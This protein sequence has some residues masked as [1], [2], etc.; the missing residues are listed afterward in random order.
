M[1]SPPQR[2]H[3]LRAR[4]DG[5]RLASIGILTLPYKVSTKTSL[6]DV[7]HL[8]GLLSSAATVDDV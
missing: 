6:N 4:V 8:L 1:L 5:W 3:E 7:P 2:A